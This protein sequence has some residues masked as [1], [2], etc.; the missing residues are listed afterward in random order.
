[1]PR[2]G[3]A[4]SGGGFRATLFHLGVVRF[5]RDA[6]LLSKVSH[7]VSVSGG[8]IFSAHLAL[9]W[10]RYTGTPEQ[11]DESASDILKFVQ[12]DVRN[13]IVRRL[14]FLIPFQLLQRI[15]L[16]GKSRF[17]SANGILERYYQGHLYGNKTVHELPRSPELHILATNVS[18]GSLCS[19]NRNG[20]LL[21]LRRKNRESTEQLPAKLA[22]LSMAVSASSAFPGFFPPVQITADEA[23][24]QEGQFPTQAFTDGGVYDNLGVR[25]FEWLKDVDPPFDKILVSDTGQIFRILPKKPLSIVGQA[26]R[27]S[28]ILWDRVWQLEKMIFETD[29]RFL[30]IPSTEVV[31][32]EEDPTALNPL[33]QSEIQ[34]IRTDLDRFSPLEI[35]ALVGHGYCV[36]RKKCKSQPNVFGTEFPDSPPWNPLEP[37]AANMEMDSTGSH[38]TP[39]FSDTFSKSGNVTSDV[40][41]IRKSAHRRVWSTLLDFRDWPTYV[42]IPLVVFLF[43]VLPYWAYQQYRQAKLNATV[44]EAIA[45][46][47]PEFRKILD[48]VKKQSLPDFG[49]TEFEQEPKPRE[50]NYTG[51]EFLETTRII[52]LRGWKPSDPHLF[53]Y[54]RVRIRKTPEFQNTDDKIRL[55]SRVTFVK[56]FDVHLGPETFN[57]TLIKTD[58]TVSRTDIFGGQAKIWQMEYDLSSVPKGKAVDL[59]SEAHFTLSESYG[60]PS[61]S[62]RMNADVA[63]TNV[64]LLFPEDRPYRKYQLLRYESSDGG[65]PQAVESRYNIEHPYGY[66]IGW[67]LINAKEGEIYE[68]QWEWEE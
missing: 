53:T 44:V 6:G 48:L 17:F 8:S 2:F 20:L 24:L 54:R 28:D 34:N 63:V 64:W 50:V 11:F 38:P 21:W 10:D 47:D 18:E 39:A 45:G 1:M 61:Y 9:N 57:P 40:R 43:A 25:A 58:E 31:D 5:L 15:G 41:S 66:L 12:L 22:K 42:Y 59:F 37:T 36:A 13:R 16:L 30:F 26:L 23:G 62:F 4:L 65:T 68:C 3:L 67:S 35:R 33:I 52:D 29:P 14:P 46:G 60:T 51:I 7:I 55:N 56:D 19:F 27:A 49:T 32:Q